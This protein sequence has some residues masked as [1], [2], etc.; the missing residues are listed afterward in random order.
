MCGI[1]ACWGASNATKRVVQGLK[2]LEYRGYDSW[3]VAVPMEAQ[4]GVY[5]NLGPVSEVDDESLLPTAQD[6]LGHTRWATHGAVDLSNCHPHVARDGSFALVHNGIIENYQALKSKLEAQG[7]NF[8]TDTDTEVVL[9]LIERIYDSGDS[10]SEAFEESVRM[11][12]LALQGRNTLAVY[13]VLNRRLVAIKNGSPLVVG[14]PLESGADAPDYMLASDP[15]AFADHADQILALQN[16][17]LISCGGGQ[18]LSLRDVASGGIKPLSWEPFKPIDSP[19][20]KGD[21]P[22]H[23][24]KE[25]GE[26]WRTIARAARIPEQQ[27]KRLAQRLE[28]TDCVYLTGAGGAFFT[29]E[30]IAFLLRSQAN[31]KAAAV[32]AYEFSSY[33]PLMTPDDLVIAVS[34]S[35]ETADT[36]EAVEACQA[37]HIFCVAL[38]NAE[39]TSLA[40]LSDMTLT[41]R[42]GP[43]ICVLSTKSATA[44]ITFGYVLSRYLVDGADASR[45]IDRLCQELCKALESSYI[46]TLRSVATSLKAARQLFILGRDCFYN[47]ARI[48]ALNIKEASYVHAEAFSGGE[49][50]HGV[51]ALIEPGTPVLLYV[52]D[53]DAESVAAAAELKARGARILAV[54]YR[55]NELFDEFIPFPTGSREMEKTIASLIPGQLLAYFLAVGRGHNP[56]RP[57]NLAKSVTVK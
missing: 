37:K 21:Y 43:E 19:V 36:L 16:G 26:Q 40:R 15:L 39:A 30:Q 53:C 35:G 25:I 24:L 57:R 55:N 10:G 49:L 22:H 27:L 38:V 1:V 45:Q 5:K 4:I 47:T 17:E 12:F 20:D 13:H 14:C 3:G 32:P 33:L 54:G 28:S 29:A 9:R 2:R 6:A 42:S 46:N 51:I 23:M 7:V 48:A 31:I 41:N 8:R 50:K 11:A 18:P 44:Q 52:D 34:Q 56:D